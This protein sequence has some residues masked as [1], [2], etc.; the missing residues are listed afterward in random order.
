MAGRAGWRRYVAGQDAETSVRASVARGAIVVAGIVI[1]AVIIA[2]AFPTRG[3]PVAGVVPTETPTESPSP[4]PSPSP[5][6]QK[7]RCESLSPEGVR[8]AVENATG[9]AGLAAATATR[10]QAAGYTINADTDIGNAPTEST[11]TTVYFRGPDNK[12]LARCLKKKFF[13]T[14]TVRPLPS[15]GIPG[16]EPAIA[17][18]VQAAVFLGSD[19]A[20]EHPVT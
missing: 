20:A 12:R 2:N 5:P 3:G 6:R 14:A 1:S 4:S 15:G 18:I 19:Y 8:V 17:P 9:T 13:P 16:T 10:L 7:L 11:S